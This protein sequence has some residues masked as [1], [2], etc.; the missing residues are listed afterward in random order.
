[1]LLV[2]NIGFSSDGVYRLYLDPPLEVREGYV[3]G[4]YGLAPS[5]SPV[6]LYYIDDD[7]A[8]SV[9]VGS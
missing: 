5:D 1:M 9:L 8:F 4:M 3:V 7:S 2:A 6:T